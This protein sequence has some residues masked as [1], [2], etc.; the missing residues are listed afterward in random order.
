MQEAEQKNE[1]ENLTE[2]VKEYLETR[3]ELAILN[4]QDRVSD[5]ASSATASL[6]IVSFSLLALLFISAG[7]ALWLN[8]VLCSSFAGF[9]CV[10]GFYLL[11]AVLVFYNQ[12][13]WIKSPI[14]NLLL[15]KFNIN[16]KDQ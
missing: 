8:R 11:L 7:V 10:A 2:N 13:R 16:E 12:E 9:F 6:I 1:L 3:Y 15:K 14:I 4:M 5:V